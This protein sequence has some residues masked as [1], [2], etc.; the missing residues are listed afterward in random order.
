MI[1]EL[2]LNVSL[3]ANIVHHERASWAEQ[4]ISG[5]VALRHDQR[6]SS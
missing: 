5:E 1:A 6:I 4:A 2:Q 3:L